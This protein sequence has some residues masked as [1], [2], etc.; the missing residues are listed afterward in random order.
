VYP[1][2]IANTTTS[3]LADRTFEVMHECPAQCWNTDFQRRERP[4]R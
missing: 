3:A 1:A 2:S 4:P